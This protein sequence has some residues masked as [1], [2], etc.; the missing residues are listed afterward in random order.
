MNSL[1]F[2]LYED[3]GS[4]INELD[5]FCKLLC[6]L[7]LVVGII[8]T[9]NLFVYFVWLVIVVFLLYLS[10][11]SV[12][13]LI[14]NIRRTSLFLFTILIMNILFFDIEDAFFRWWIFSPS[15]NGFIRGIS[16]VSRLV[17]LLCLSYILSSSASSLKFAKSLEI[18]FFPLKFVGINVKLISLILS[19]ALQ[20]IPI[21]YEEAESIKKAQIAR[22]ANFNSKNIKLRIISVLSLITPVFVAAF[23]RA[24][25]L[26]IAM[27]GRSYDLDDKSFYGLSFSFKKNEFLAL[28]F[29]LFC[30]VLSI[31][32]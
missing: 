26:A 32:L 15:L 18:L 11:L 3:N 5:A 12:V 10:K 28:V 13:P 8:C 31:Y 24:D 17:L 6:F 25:D 2:G 21:L 29:C 22:G 27:E 19:I 1:P 4:F 14:L 7:F 23:K 9:S 30:C 20:F 16:V